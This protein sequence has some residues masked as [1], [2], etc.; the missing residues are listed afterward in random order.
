MSEVAQTFLDQTLTDLDGNG[1]K[2]TLRQLSGSQGRRV[3]VDGRKVLNFCSNNYLGLADDARLG[4]A[5]AE[6]IERD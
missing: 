4:R 5:A 2:R 6:S 1:L 3:T